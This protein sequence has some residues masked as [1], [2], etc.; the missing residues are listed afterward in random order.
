MEIKKLYIQFDNNESVSAYFK[1]K[2]SQFT[3]AEALP[4]LQKDPEFSVSMEEKPDST[5]YK[6]KLN[7]PQKLN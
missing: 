3:Y 1:N 6:I 4:M 2:Y 7:T 5:F